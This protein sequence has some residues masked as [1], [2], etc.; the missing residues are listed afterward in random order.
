MA[1][2]TAQMVLL[3]LT[4]EKHDVQACFCNL[5]VIGK[6]LKIG[7]MSCLGQELE[8]VNDKVLFVGQLWFLEI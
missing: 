3:V 6:S 8:L 1:A 7:G 4:D 5:A 2:L